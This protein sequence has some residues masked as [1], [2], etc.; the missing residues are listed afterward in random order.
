[1]DLIYFLLLA[2]S[3][4]LTHFLK[5]KMKDGDESIKTIFKYF[6]EHFTSTL[7]AF[8]S[9]TV[10]VIAIYSELREQLTMLSSIGVGYSFDSLL[11]KW[12]VIGTDN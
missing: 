9:V 5:K 4:M 8:I 6:G 11:N 3:G 7:I 10:T 2:Y 12:S 1:M